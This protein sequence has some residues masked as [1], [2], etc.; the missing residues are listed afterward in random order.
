MI[1]KLQDLMLGLQ[2][3]SGLLRRGNE[4]LSKHFKNLLM[5]KW[6][7][8]FSIDYRTDSQRQCRK[9]GTIC[10]SVLFVEFLSSLHPLLRALRSLKPPKPSTRTAARGRHGSSGRGLSTSRWFSSWV[11]TQSISTADLRE[12][13]PNTEEKPNGQEAHYAGMHLYTCISYV[14]T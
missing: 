12:L 11:A 6:S 8:Y 14:Y 7:R 9:A 10:E 13:F 2:L 3:Q 4:F 5:W 1:V